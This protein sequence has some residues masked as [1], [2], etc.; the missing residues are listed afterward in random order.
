MILEM[1]D[2]DVHPQL[3]RRNIN[4]HD[5]VTRKKKN[6]IKRRDFCNKG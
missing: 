4:F 5:R 6:Q 2:K 3:C 1:F